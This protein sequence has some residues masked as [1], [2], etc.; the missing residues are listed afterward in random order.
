MESIHRRCRHT[1]SLRAY[2]LLHLGWAW[3]WGGM[4]TSEFLDHSVWF[5]LLF[6]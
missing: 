1:P 3:P 6:G 5:L 2:I 4:V